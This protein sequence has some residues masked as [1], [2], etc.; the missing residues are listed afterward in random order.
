MPRTATDAM[1]VRRKTWLRVTAVIIVE[2]NTK[3]TE[4]ITKKLLLLGHV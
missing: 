2:N 3:S 1:K 4:M